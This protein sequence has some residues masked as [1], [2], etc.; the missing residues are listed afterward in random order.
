[1]SEAAVYNLKGEMVGKENLPDEV[2]GVK[3]KPQV[4]HL[5]VVA[6]MANSRKNIAHTKTRGEVRGGG[7]KPWRQ[8]GTGRARHGSIRS[9]IWRGG[10]ITFGPRKEKNF[11]IK[12]NK[13]VRRAALLMALSEK[14]REHHINLV[15]SLQFE[16]KKTKSAHEILL[17]MGCIKQ[18][19]KK[20]R[21]QENKTSKKQYP[22][23]IVLPKLGQEYIRFFKNLP[24][25]TTIAS[26]S[27]N[28]IDIL[29]HRNLVMPKEALR[30][31]TD[32]YRLKK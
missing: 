8:K 31:V 10:G 26:N 13:Q 21:N 29:R 18:K 30:E 28:V 20:T 17:K 22:T 2:F 25:V 23:L 24:K 5:A 9:P 4:V 16:N 27:L 14:A 1:M 11:Y 32:M 15:E 7:K 19:N 6:Q 12:I 3:L